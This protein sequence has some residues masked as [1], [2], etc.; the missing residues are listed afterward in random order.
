MGWLTTYW[1]YT[2]G[3][4]AADNGSLRLDMENMPQPD[5]ALIILPSHGGQV[6]LDVDDYVQGGPELA[7]EVAAS[8]VSIDLNTKL[9]VYCRNGVREYVVWRVQNQA[10]DWFVLRQGQYD[11]LAPDA[12]GILRSEVFPGLWLDAAALTRLDLPTVLQ[13]LHQGLA[14]PEHAAFV[15]ELA[16]RAARA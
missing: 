10:I 13:V 9:R 5:G 4:D 12:A 7:A 11:R 8:T 14:S 3:T 6:R 2:P 15:K 16:R 1:A